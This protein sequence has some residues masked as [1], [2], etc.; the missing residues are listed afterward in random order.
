MPTIRFPKIERSFRKTGICPA[1]GKKASRSKVAWATVNPFNLDPSTRLPRTPEQVLE[2]VRAEG[3]AWEAEP[4]Y[5][6]RCEP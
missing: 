4:V 2:C 3:R 5:H 1:C 6:A